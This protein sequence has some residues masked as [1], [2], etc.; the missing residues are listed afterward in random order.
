MLNY[1]KVLDMAGELYC[2]SGDRNKNMPLARYV[3]LVL[4]SHLKDGADETDIRLLMLAA[5]QTALAV[6]TKNELD[7]DGFSSFRAGDV[8]IESN[9]EFTVKGLSEKCEA[10]RAECRDLLR[11][12]G[13]VFRCV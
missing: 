9:T 10:L 7:G 12:E 13:F 6:L 5:T 1:G 11:D 2:L 8:A 4:E 3:C